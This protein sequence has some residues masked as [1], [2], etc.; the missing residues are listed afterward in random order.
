MYGFIYKTT[1]LVNGKMYIGKRHFDE[2]GKWKEYIGSGTIL[3][4][5]IAKYGK[6]NFQKEILQI[7]KNENELISAEIDWI[8]FYDAANSDMFYNIASGGNGGNTIAGY[9]QNQLDEYRKR[10][11]LIHKLSAARGENSGNAVIT[12]NEAL[13]IIQ[14]LLDSKYDDEIAELYNISIS[15][16]Q[17]IRHHRTW[18]YLTDNIQFP[19]IQKRLGNNGKMIVQYDLSGNIISTFKS[20]VEAEQITNINKK[21]ISA[22]CHGNKRTANGYIW[23]FYGDDFNKFSVKKKS[24]VAIDKFDIYGN[25]IQTYNSIKDAAKSIG[26]TPTSIQSVLRNRTHTSGGYIWKYH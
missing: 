21:L 1:N 14:L 7:C 12:E 3:K 23:R 2:Q 24:E 10:K 13:E 8:S 18:C 25:Y 15:S 26:N 20:A 16:V 17:D 11:S 9:N 6:D 5:A 4:R 19:T 22:V